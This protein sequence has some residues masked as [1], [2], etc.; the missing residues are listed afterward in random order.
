MKMNS[1]WVKV[2]KQTWFF[3]IVSGFISF[4]IASS[5][6]HASI[7]GLDCRNGMDD[8][9]IFATG[10]EYDSFRATIT[11]LGHTIMPIS[12]FEAEDL[13][14]LDSLIV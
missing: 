9:T 8:S 3:A 11:A 2:V 4:I 6:S 10:D 7:I 1:S 13:V 5:I 14:G 12:S